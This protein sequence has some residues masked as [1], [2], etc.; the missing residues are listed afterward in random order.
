MLM[1][2]KYGRTVDLGQ[3]AFARF[4]GI[5]RE[6]VCYPSLEIHVKPQDLER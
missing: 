2:Q 3:L 1:N 5:T 6:V 4:F